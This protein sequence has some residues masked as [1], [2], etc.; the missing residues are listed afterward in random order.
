MKKCSKCGEVKDELMFYVQKKINKE[1]EIVLYLT[2]PCIECRGTK[3]RHN[4]SIQ[5]VGSGR[6]KKR[7]VIDEEYVNNLR[8]QIRRFVRVIIARNYNID[9]VDMYKILHYYQF[10]GRFIWTNDGDSVIDEIIMN[11]ERLLEFYQND[12]ELLI[13][14]CLK[15]GEWRSFADMR[16]KSKCNFCYSQMMQIYKSEKK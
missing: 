13:K 8:L 3:K 7:W 16:G 5:K 6:P 14:P 1:G 4:K 10:V 9:E 15:C 11:W 12:E 2:T